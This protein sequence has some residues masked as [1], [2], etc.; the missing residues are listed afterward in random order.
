MIKQYWLEKPIKILLDDNQELTIHYIGPV[1]MR[2]RDRKNIIY[3]HQIVFPINNI[4]RTKTNTQEVLVREY[5]SIDYT[6]LLTTKEYESI[7]KTLR[8]I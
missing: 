2:Y 8:E 3:S 6:F 5:R 7:F 1:C 4:R